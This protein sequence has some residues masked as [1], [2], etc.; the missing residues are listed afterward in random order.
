[1]STVV[2]YCDTGLA[3]IV[4]KVWVSGGKGWR[5]EV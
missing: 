4:Q 1:M 3:A 5:V 2:G